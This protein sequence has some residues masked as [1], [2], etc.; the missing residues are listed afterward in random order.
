[1]ITP[2]IPEKQL[3]ASLTR[4]EAF[5]KGELEEGPLL[6]VT[7]AGAAPGAGS[8]SPPK[9]PPTDEEQ[10]MDVSYQ[11]EKAEYTLAHSYFA[12]D[13]LP[14]H[15]PW[16]GPDQFAAWLGGS[17][18]FST[19]DNT[20]WTKP[21]IEDWAEFPDFRID[22][23]NRWWRTYLEILRASVERGKG[24][25]VTAY[26][27][28]H[29]G[30]DGLG[31]MRGPERLML[32]LVTEPDVIARAIGQM[33]RLWKEIVDTVSGIVLPGGQGTTNWT[34]G[35]SQ[36]RFLCVGQNDFSCLISPAM[37]DQFVLADTRACCGHVERSIYHLDGPGALQHVPRILELEDL[38]CVQWI[39]GAGAPLP[40][41]WL[42]LLR[43]IQDGG[44]SVQLMYSGAHGGKADFRQ[45][46]D[47]LCGALDVSRLFITADVDSIEKAD[48]IV[49][50]V[51][52]V[53]RGAR[54]KPL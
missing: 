44:K 54:T 32:D 46:I 9:A 45:E 11:V 40:S 1:M 39:Q 23:G 38:D 7:A 28:L 51:R 35:W 17:L 5:W 53:C 3:K 2:W 31:A 41:Y 34:Y 43:R 21:F 29:T 26:P 19:K 24:R 27:D 25:W 49:R 10:W 16:L 33:T 47:A 18:S 37:F 36:E 52:E 15:N 50:H 6:W 20:S 13:S 14:I 42:S 8:A 12:A 22:P 48:F 30:I 4:N